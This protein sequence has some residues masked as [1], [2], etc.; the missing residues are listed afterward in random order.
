MVDFV[1]RLTIENRGDNLGYEPRA[2]VFAHRMAPLR[3]IA[4]ESFLLGAG[5]LTYGTVLFLNC[6]SQVVPG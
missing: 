3:L 2:R 4:G 1:K 5:A 6:L